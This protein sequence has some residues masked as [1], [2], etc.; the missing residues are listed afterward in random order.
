MTTRVSTDKHQELLSEK[1]G[2]GF[3]H[4]VMMDDA[5]E[6]IGV[7]NGPRNAE[8]F[9]KTGEGAQRYVELRAKAQ[10]GDEAAKAEYLLLRMELGLIEYA[11]A[12]AEAE[13][14]KLSPEQQKKF[15]GLLLDLEVNLMFESLR[16]EADPQA[17]M[18]ELGKLWLE[19]S[20]KGQLPVGEQAFLMFHM[21]IFQYC[22]GTKDVAGFKSA[23]ANMEGRFGQSEDPRYQQMMGSLRDTLKELEGGAGGE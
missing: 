3:P 17:K 23:L 14:V 13:G 4:L 5:G 18:K 8:G 2:R 22:E 20:K 7:H 6:V 11:D 16:N 10:K 21:M 15:D 9:K 12:E 19:K 1:G